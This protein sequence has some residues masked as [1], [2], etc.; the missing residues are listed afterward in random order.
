MRFYVGRL[1]ALLDIAYAIICDT[2]KRSSFKFMSYKSFKKFV[3]DLKENMEIF[4][5]D[6]QGTIHG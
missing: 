6:Y 4:V 1:A 5:A 3:Q 2:L